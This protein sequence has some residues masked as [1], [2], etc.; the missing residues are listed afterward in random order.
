M[1]KK[2]LLD[3][4]LPTIVSRNY[5]IVFSVFLSVVF[6]TAAYW[7]L[8]NRNG[9]LHRENSS[10]FTSAVLEGELA[11]NAG[12]LRAATVGVYGFC[13]D[14]SATPEQKATQKSR[15]E[16]YARKLEDSFKKAESHEQLTA[17]AKKAISKFHTEVKR[18][19][20][21]YEKNVADL[22]AGKLTFGEAYFRGQKEFTEARNAIITDSNDDI[23]TMQENIL[24]GSA[25]NRRSLIIMIG[26]CVVIVIVLIYSGR[27]MAHT[28]SRGMEICERI[29]KY[30]S[31]QDYQSLLSDNT[32]IGELEF[33]SIVDHQ[34]VA[35]R[36]LNDHSLRVNSISSQVASAATELAASVE[37]HERGIDEVSSQMVDIQ[38]ILDGVNT[39]ATEIQVVAK[40]LQGISSQLLDEQ[41]T[42]QMAAE[43]GL[44][45]A[46]RAKAALQSIAEFADRIKE[47]TTAINEIANQTNLLSLNAA[48]EA[49]KAGEF[50]KGFSVVAEEIR[51]LAD[52]S[53]AM[54][55]EIE[56]LLEKSSS[57][58]QTGQSISQEQH[59][60]SEIIFQHGKQVIDT[61]NKVSGAV[62]QQQFSVIAITESTKQGQDGISRAGSAVHQI[63][64]GS[65]EVRRTANELHRLA[66]GL[67]EIALSAKTFNK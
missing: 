50:G 36:K 25:Q 7:Q 60:G 61:V 53:A 26:S 6:F 33:T 24:T 34:I 44:E 42:S 8:D 63:S 9:K 15:V 46:E 1:K 62:S 40:S 21:M 58:V 65:H 55:R 27:K 39:Q 67:R 56:A 3:R 18:Y 5:A 19:R 2:S 49:A 20:T 43:S 12:N 64:A 28:I 11:N 16:D 35:A 66:E 57:A 59:E 51:K 10:G 14:K 38:R 30:M 23:Q 32:L 4:L 13:I 52:H 47:V 48:I 45:R 29:A 22:E 31:N 17:D 41:A 37:E 54:S